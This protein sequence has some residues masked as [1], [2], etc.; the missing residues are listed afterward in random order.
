MSVLENLMIGAHQMTR[1]GLIQ[2]LVDLRG[3]KREEKLLIERAEEVLE[4]I[5]MADLRHE[6]SR[7]S[8]TASRK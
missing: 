5:G 3:E 6:R 4:E 2:F 7:T 8:P 1:I